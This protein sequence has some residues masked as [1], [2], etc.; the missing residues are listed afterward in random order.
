MRIAY[1]YII[2]LLSPLSAFAQNNGTSIQGNINMP[3]LIQLDVN[4]PENLN[5]GFDN[6]EEFAKG[7]VYPNCINLAVKSNCPW[8]ITVR[9]GNND[10]ATAAKTSTTV[11]SS[12]IS[13]K[14]SNSNE[15]VSVSTTPK[16]LLVSDNDNV[17]NNYHLDLKMGTPWNAEGGKYDLN[18]VFSISAQ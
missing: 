18:F 5:I 17:I 11:P 2:G 13:V 15:Y 12:I 1:I 14:P 10:F 9:S 6:L 8:V 7:K 16:P 4:Y 3:S